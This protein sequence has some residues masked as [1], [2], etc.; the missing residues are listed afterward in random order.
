MGRAANPSR[1]PFD[2]PGRPQ[3]RRRQDHGPSFVEA[4]RGEALAEGDCAHLR[5]RL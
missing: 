5:R 1:S 4:S 2:S 3:L